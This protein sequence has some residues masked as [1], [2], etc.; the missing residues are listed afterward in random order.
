[1]AG[2]GCDDCRR[3]SAADPGVGGF[4]MRHC[5]P[6]SADRGKDVD[7]DGDRIYAGDVYEG[8]C[9]GSAADLGVRGRG[10]ELG[11]PYSMSARVAGLVA[12]CES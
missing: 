2:D 3:G 12:A 9:G 4:E 7:G 10:V 5:A 8:C 6:C 11:A 1:M